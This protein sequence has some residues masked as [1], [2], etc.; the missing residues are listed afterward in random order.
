MQATPK[1]DKWT[2]R[3]S[4]Y[5]HTQKEYHP[6]IKKKEILPSAAMQ[7]D[8]ENIRPSEIYLTNTVWYHLYVEF[9]KVIQ[10]AVQ[11]ETETDSQTLKTKYWL[12]ERREQ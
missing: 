7:M 10:T 3:C 9:F 4:V 1:K 11:R 5:T 12:P 2:S 8:L 6:A